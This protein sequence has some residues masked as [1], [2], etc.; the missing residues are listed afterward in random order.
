L[1]AIRV[2]L[3]STTIGDFARVDVHAGEYGE[4][5]GSW[6][7]MRVTVQRDSTIA[8]RA[9]KHQPSQK[10]H[11]DQRPQN[12]TGRFRPRP[13]PIFL[14]TIRDDRGQPEWRVIAS[15]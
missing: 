5:H 12:A 2:S 1:F 9:V 3:D 8:S 10:D 11:G 13:T 6:K 14:A 15:R 7:R 4:A